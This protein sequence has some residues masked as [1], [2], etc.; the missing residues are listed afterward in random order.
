MTGKGPGA[1]DLVIFDWAGTMVDFGCC[2]PIAAF[3]EAFAR[4][5]VALDEAAA[6]ADMG[7]AK[8]DHVR[9]LLA[10]PEVAAAWTEA[11]GRPSDE[12]DVDALM[13]DL[14]PLMRDAATVASELIPGAAETVR[15]LR[16]R[17]LRIASSTGYTREMMGPVLA[18]AAEQGYAPDHLVCAGETPQGR[19]SPLMIYKA[20]AELG[21][22]PLSRVV[23]VDDAEA[24]IAEGRAAGC[25]T[26]GVAASGNAVGVS[27]AAFSALGAADRERRLSVARAALLG[28]GA[29][30]VIDTVAELPAALSI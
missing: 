20:C 12:G 21:V 25:Y 7:V 1:F 3:V 4:R 17:G 29:D 18:R 23:K 22:W 30:L 2:A 6:R 27:L 14:G 28:A 13:A 11:C 5:G 10:R 9:A 26:V 24:G 19:P 15:K 8:V 16:A